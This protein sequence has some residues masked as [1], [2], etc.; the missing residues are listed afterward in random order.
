[1]LAPLGKIRNRFRLINT[2]SWLR[3]TIVDDSPLTVLFLG[4]T[5][6]FCC[7]VELEEEEEE[8]KDT[9]QAMATTA[10]KRS[11]RVGY[12]E[13]PDEVDE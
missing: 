13:R 5:S 10:S 4:D 6:G 9:G 12:I 7:S 11:A 2:R 8:E 3:G 1:M